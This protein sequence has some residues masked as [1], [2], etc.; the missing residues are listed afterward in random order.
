[1]SNIPDQET[2]YYFIDA[3]KLPAPKH[4]F[5]TLQSSGILSHTV[6]YRNATEEEKN[7]FPQTYDERL[8]N[9]AIYVSQVNCIPLDAIQPIPEKQLSQ[10]L[11]DLH[12]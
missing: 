2:Y 11:G 5:K 7:L 10:I 8:V 9:A 3:A 4:P 1:M 6:D 12:K